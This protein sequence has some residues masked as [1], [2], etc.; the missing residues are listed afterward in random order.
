[1]QR[2]AVCSTGELRSSI[3]KRDVHN[4]F[5]L[6]KETLPSPGG[7]ENVFVRTTD[8]SEVDSEPP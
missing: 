4:R 7:A 1:V 2:R 8:F 5:S 6:G 3:S